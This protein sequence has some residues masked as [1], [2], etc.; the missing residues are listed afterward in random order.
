MHNVV[1]YGATYQAYGLYKFLSDIPG[2]DVEFINYTMN[3]KKPEYKTVDK[4][5]SIIKRRIRQIKHFKRYFDIENKKRKFYIFWDKKFICSENVYH[6]DAE[7]LANVPCYDLFIAGSDQLFN[8]TLTNY[9]IGYFLPFKVKKISYSTSFG[10]NSLDK[11]NRSEV[12]KLLEDFKA[13][14]VRELSASAIL[15]EELGVENSVTADPVFLLEPEVWHSIS[16]TIRLPKKYIL[17][18]I[19]SNNQNLKACLDWIESCEKMPIII[20]KTCR[21]DIGIKGKQMNDLG[22]D[23]FLFVIENA[24]Y[25][26]TNSFH[27]CA[28]SIIFGKKIFCLEEERFKGDKRY[29]A[30]L[31]EAG[32]TN[33]IVP[34]DTDWDKFNYETHL[35]DGFG[36]YAN[37]NDWVL[38]SKQYLLDNMN[39][40]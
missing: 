3:D 17:C 30:M 7:L 23:E 15:K 18:Y 4:R 27:G 34:Y 39:E 29:E 11:N 20:V 35:I 19:M 28:L 22:P 40:P 12:K 38:K 16:K 13:V 24:S 5:E 14:S 2:V 6:G 32:I 25:V 9:S 26:L 10:M 21:D 37:M 31:A 36:A 8:L 1:N 33:C